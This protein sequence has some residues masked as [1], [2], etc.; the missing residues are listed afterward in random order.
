MSF[1]EVMEQLPSLTLQQ[2]Q[3][4]VRRALELDDSPLSLADEVLVENRLAAHRQNPA[5]SVPLE[6]MN[7]SLRAQFIL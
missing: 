6:T 1:A 3:V 2:R 5:S 4:L 7:T